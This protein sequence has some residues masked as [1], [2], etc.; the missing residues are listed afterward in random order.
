MLL[1][2]QIN[3]SRRQ[4]EQ[5]MLAFTIAMPVTFRGGGGCR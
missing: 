5:W 4:W 1:V 3:G 2:V